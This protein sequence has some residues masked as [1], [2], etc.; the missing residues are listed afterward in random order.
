MAPEK[1]ADV[2]I[3]DYFTY[4]DRATRATTAAEVRALRA[5][6]RQRWPG[7]P[8]ADDLV[9]AL[10]VHQERLAAHEMPRRAEAGPILNGGDTRSSE[11]QT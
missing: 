1:P 2:S 3:R 10:S 7:K 9:E 4:L 5:E 8:W 6:V 11:R